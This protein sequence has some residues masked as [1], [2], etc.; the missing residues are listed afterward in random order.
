MG[1]YRRISLMILFEIR[2]SDAEVFL[3]F[4]NDISSFILFGDLTWERGHFP[5]PVSPSYSQGRTPFEDGYSAP[6]WGPPQAKKRGR[7]VI[8]EECSQE[9][10]FFL[11]R[12]LT[13]PE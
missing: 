3:F 2:V 7:V 6:D 8:H 5:Y 4:L 13:T 12:G 1:G 9:G 11:D 10:Q